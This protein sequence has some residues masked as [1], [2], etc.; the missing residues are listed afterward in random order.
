MND[1]NNTAD[2]PPKA[3]IQP[4]QIISV[5]FRMAMLPVC[6]LLPAGKLWWPEAWG[7]TALYYAW[8]GSL[9]WWLGRNNLELL[10]E[11]MR[12]PIQREQKTWDKVIMGLMLITSL[13]MIVL[14]G[15][16][17]VRWK[18]TQ[19]PLY[20]KI[21]GFVLHLP[22]FWM[23][24]LT[25]KE[26]TFLARVVRIQDEKAQTV[27]TTGPYAWVRHP[28]YSGVIFIYLG[29]PMALGSYYA[30]LCGVLSIL[31]LAVRTHF[32]DQT[33]QREL[34][35]YKDYTTKTRYRLLP[36]IW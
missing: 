10:K 1:P 21:I 23:V 15:L 7:I 2:T 11:R 18:L 4:A 30:L 33:L 13:P 35:G 3:S 19:M 28:M 12:G 5:I 26:N 16:E 31:V 27:V 17:V 34:D 36:Y 32:E 20:I 22:G 8:A 29:L 14:P 25:M 9:V 6:F 24:F